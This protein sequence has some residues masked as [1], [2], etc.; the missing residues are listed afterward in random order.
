MNENPEGLRAEIW[1]TEIDVA[2]W[3]LRRELADVLRRY[4]ESLGRPITPAELSALAD[5]FE[6]GQMGDK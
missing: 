6:A 4:A 5:V 2:L 1:I 3:M